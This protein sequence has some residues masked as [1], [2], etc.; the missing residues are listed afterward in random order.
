MS[1][2]GILL[3]ISVLIIFIS[4]V[5]ILRFW[6]SV[7]LFSTLLFSAGVHASLKRSQGSPNGDYSTPEGSL[8][9]SG[10]ARSGSVP[11]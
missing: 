2:L 8:P 6:P 4:L 10:L 3:V 9:P 7:I 5:S 1:A 11:Q